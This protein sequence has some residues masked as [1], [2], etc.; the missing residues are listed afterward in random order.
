MGVIL[1][2]SNK[3]IRLLPLTGFNIVAQILPESPPCQ[4]KNVKHDL[5]AYY[6]A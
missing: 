6:T 1:Q 4:P 2:S 5:N 3:A